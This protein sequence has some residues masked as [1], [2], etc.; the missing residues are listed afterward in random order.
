MTVVHTCAAV[1][2][3]VTDSTAF[4]AC[5]NGGVQA[6]PLTNT[7][8]HSA[9]GSVPIQYIGFTNDQDGVA[10]SGVAQSQS[11]AGV[12]YLTRDGG[13]HWTKAAT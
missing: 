11:D 1:S 3:A 8:S 6:V 2:L 9:I 5:R 10:I 4:V 12:L 13:A 7:I